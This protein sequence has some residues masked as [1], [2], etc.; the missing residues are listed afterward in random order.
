LLEKKKKML[1]SEKMVVKCTEDVLQFARRVNQLPPTPLSL[2]LTVYI[3]ENFVQSVA[4]GLEIMFG[5]IKP[6]HHNRVQSLFLKIVPTGKQNDIAHNPNQ[7]F[8]SQRK[9][10]SLR[11]LSLYLSTKQDS[12]SLTDLDTAL[13]GLRLK[14]IHLVNPQQ[15]PRICSTIVSNT[16]H[17]LTSL[18]IQT[19]LKHNKI[20]VGHLNSFVNTIATT[21]SDV[22]KLHITTQIQHLEA[23]L[24]PMGDPSGTYFISNG[25]LCRLLSRN[26]L[27]KEL[28]IR[29][30]VTNIRSE[31]CITQYALEQMA[32][33]LNMTMHMTKFALE[34]VGI[35]NI[36]AEQLEKMVSL[37][38]FLQSISLAD[39]HSA[40]TSGLQ[41]LFKLP[42]RYLQ[43]L[44]LSN[45]DFKH[46]RNLKTLTTFVE[47]C[48]TLR[49]LNL[50]D[51][52]FPAKKKQLQP[53]LEACLDHP[54]M[55]ELEMHLK[56]VNLTKLA[57][58]TGKAMAYLEACISGIQSNKTDYR[59]RKKTVQTLFREYM[60]AP[61]K[62][63]ELKKAIK[64][65]KPVDMKLLLHRMNTNVF[66]Y[67]EQKVVDNIDNLLTE[68]YNN[69]TLEQPVL[70]QPVL[71]RQYTGG[72]QKRTL[73]GGANVQLRSLET[74]A[75][76]SDTIHNHEKKSDSD[77]CASSSSSNTNKKCEKKSDSDK[78]A[79]SSSSNTNH[80]K[81]KKTRNPALA[82]HGIRKRF[83]DTPSPDKNRI[84]RKKR[85]KNAVAPLVPKKKI[86]RIEIVETDLVL[87]VMNG[88]GVA[89]GFTL[90]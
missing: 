71:E 64:A 60:R 87:R 52:L 34:Q 68:H 16:K 29:S 76:V 70:E 46:Y 1:T 82:M 81:K 41:W 24:T 12:G 21:L 86:A 28:H 57:D 53:F 5:R 66:T 35:R 10:T 74:T 89:N 38:P 62:R 37:F 72:I 26:V 8:V 18:K 20:N 55:E 39:N 25:P 13:R 42:L 88:K 6:A 30:N 15:A 33:A 31:L 84:P 75:Y 27:L 3:G 7:S 61:W 65:L 85:R 50:S 69:A 19:S 32:H 79:S 90:N 49:V 45:T 51:N 11:S 36:H 80:K 67:N 43:V 58:A 48:E 54:E 4:V 73:D 56:E 59:E 17:Y 63:T 14:K 9:F 40:Q 2:K 77:K 22:S 23:L 44:D 83:L 78:C 47:R